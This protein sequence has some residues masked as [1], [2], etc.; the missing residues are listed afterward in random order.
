MTQLSMTTKRLITATALAL[1]VAAIVNLYV[2]KAFGSHDR[3]VLAGTA[4]LLAISLLTI[5]PSIQEVA[6][7]RERR[8]RR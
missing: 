5:G 7:E 3:Q 4:M 1:L 6:H 8:R 2:I